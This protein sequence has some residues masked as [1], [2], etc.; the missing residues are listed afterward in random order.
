MFSVPPEDYDDYG[1]FI[2][3]AGSSQLTQPARKGRGGIRR[4]KGAGICR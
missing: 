1:L 3:M 4:E 2:T